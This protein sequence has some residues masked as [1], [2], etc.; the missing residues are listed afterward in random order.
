M[1]LFPIISMTVI[2]LVFLSYI[3]PFNA[4]TGLALPE[5]VNLTFLLLFYLVS[6]FIIVF[7]NVGLVS[8]ARIRLNGGDPTF[9][10]GITNARKHLRGI[11]LWAMISATVG[12][13]LTALTGK[14]KKGSWLAAPLSSLWTL[15]TFFVIPVM[16]FENK[17]VFQSI[18]SA[19]Q[20][21][22]RTWGETVVGSFSIGLIFGLLGLLG[23][24][25]FFAAFWCRS[26]SITIILPALAAVIFYW[27][28]LGI[29]GSTLTGI[30]R[31]VLYEYAT[32]GRIHQGF[33]VTSVQNAFVAKK[34]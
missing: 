24:I 31:A 14:T 19:G 1:L 11:F 27:V 23:V 5:Q 12:L 8:C 10:D 22:K 6:Y 9:K 20:L 30:F 2:I 16:I 17:S 13:L 26:C 25:P 28:F 33:D 21:L 29:M 32:T 15:L 34:Q 4:Y 3:I 7:F 18:K